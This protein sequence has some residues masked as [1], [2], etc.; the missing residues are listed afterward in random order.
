MSLPSLRRRLAGALTAWR[1]GGEDAP[2]QDST[3]PEPWTH[4][5]LTADNLRRFRAWSGQVWE[6]AQAV[7]ERAPLDVA[8]CVNMAQN[9]YNWARLAQER[10]ARAT[11]YL[12]PWDRS[13]ISQPQWEE[14]DGEF[15]DVQNG[16]GF[17][18]A[19]GHLPCQVPVET[20]PMDDLGLDAAAEAWVWG[21]RRALLEFD[22]SH[23]GLRLEA[24]LL[25]R[26]LRH[27]ARWAEALQRHDVAFAASSPLAAW[28]SGRP[29]LAHTVGGDLL[30]DA[31]RGDGYGASM[32][33][34]FR[35]ARLFTFTNP[36]TLAYCRRL[37]LSNAV[38]LPYAVDD[39]RYCPG[40][41]RARRAWQETTGGSVFVLA[42]CR[43]DAAYKGHDEGL[44]A[45]LAECARAHPEVR[46]VF[47]DW[48]EHAHR[49]RER[50]AAQGLSGSFLLLPPVGKQ[51]LIDYLRSCDVVLD[52]FVYGYYGA[53]GLE[54]AAI[55]RP[56]VMRVESAHYSPLYEG[57]VAPI[58]HAGS[59]REAREVLQ[60]LVADPARREQRGRIL[61][62]WLVRQHG[63]DRV[64][65]IQLALLRWAA[66]GAA[67]PPELRSPL[68][69]P[70]SEAERTRHAACRRP[71]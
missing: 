54:A 68:A 28:L 35:N 4:P 65:P 43:I 49:L 51:R 12:H 18:A 25:L 56:L 3:D 16:E 11:L 23:P 55:G 47:L 67:L 9:T 19:H 22:A 50:I 7:P 53:T 70:E 42:T 2:R 69:E 5:W 37:G 60:R 1:S 63:A 29:Y 14:F 32:L 24:T 33:L 26:E 27:C 15:P 45:A 31:G 46:F 38:Y 21:E 71:A 13:A 30:I 58:D 8:Y 64:M 40:P 6:L 41:G 48:G 61:R 10:G 17:L 20:I 52:Q 39:R 57:D 62:D 44:W 66:S 36:F 59:P 34:S